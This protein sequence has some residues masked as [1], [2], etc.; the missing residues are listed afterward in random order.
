MTRRIR[1]RRACSNFTQHNKVRYTSSS[2]VPGRLTT[3]NGRERGSTEG[4]T[5]SQGPILQTA[6]YQD[7]GCCWQVLYRAAQRGETCLAGWGW[8]LGLHSSIVLPYQWPAL[9]LLFDL[10]IPARESSSSSNVHPRKLIEETKRH[11]CHQLTVGTQAAPT[12]I[13]GTKHHLA[14]NNKQRRSRSSLPPETR[15]RPSGSSGSVASRFGAKRCHR[16]VR[17]GLTP[18]APKASNDP[19]PLE[20]W[21]I[22]PQASQRSTSATI[23]SNTTSLPPP[24]LPPSLVRSFSLV[25]ETRSEPPLSPDLCNCLPTRVAS[26]RANAAS[27]APT[28]S[29]HAESQLAGQA[30][31]WG[32]IIYPLYRL[33]YHTLEQ[34]QPL[35]SPSASTA[36]H[37]TALSLPDPH[38]TH[39]APHLQGSADKTTRMKDNH[40]RRICAAL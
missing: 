22:L 37:S 26:C 35:A 1:A 23:T 11:R 33:D 10:R 27:I 21:H 38:G 32:H 36:C 30:L 8:L 24:P 25:P 15:V 20:S 7:A 40:T 9:E 13:S 3:V 12:C 29:V 34:C 19:L 17:Q 6:G 28:E 16:V 18:L 5:R 2:E 31:R 4:I 39:H 14:N